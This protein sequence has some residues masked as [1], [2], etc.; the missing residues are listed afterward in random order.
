[1]MTNGQKEQFCVVAAALLAPPDTSLVDDLKQ[2][3]LRAWLENCVEDLG[4][5]RELLLPFFTE[6]EGNDFLSSLRTEYARLF[7]QQKETTIS[8]VES[9]YKP[10]TADKSCA[11][12][13]ATSTGLLMG[14][15]AAH[16][17]D[18]YRQASIEIPDEFRS[19]PDHLVLELEF[20]AFLYRVGSEEQSKQFISDHLDWIPELQRKT[21]EAGTYPFYRN[22]VELI[23]LFLQHQ[24]K[25][26][27]VEAHE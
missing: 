8:L 22:S 18:L 13:F 17:L 5:D 27:K 23:R 2:G 24:A 26:G 25:N 21:K 19:M 11:M 10:W 12:V 7:D 4:T 20:L 3:E 14:D 6:S 15:C 1:M 16:M 9:T